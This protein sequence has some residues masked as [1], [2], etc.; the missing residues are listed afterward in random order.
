MAQRK[1][2]AKK[3]KKKSAAASPTPKRTLKFSSAAKLTL[4]LLS[5]ML[6]IGG[7]MGFLTY[8]FGRDSLRGITQPDVNPFL[9]QAK[10]S[11]QNPRQGISFLKEA[12]LIKQ[13]KAQ[14]QGK[15]AAKATPKPKETSKAQEESQKDEKK[16]QKPKQSAKKAPKSFPI[17]LESQGVKLNIRSMEQ[18]D[19]DLLLTVALV[20]TSNEPVQFIYTFLD[21]TDNQGFALS[22]EVT[23]L[24][25]T[26]PPN[27]ETYVGSITVFDSPEDTI[28]R[29]NLKLS[30]YPEQKVVLEVIDIQVASEKET[31]ET[32]S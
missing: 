6:L 10:D 11:E 32:E 15:S 5:L 25:E 7:G 20:N 8:L 27:S 29:L 12:E 18:K 1:L 3:Q 17:N 2:Q 26:L 24:P 30:D 28:E 16:A 9:N 23:G 22:S 31:Q 4:F 21:V 13:V 19:D 14:T